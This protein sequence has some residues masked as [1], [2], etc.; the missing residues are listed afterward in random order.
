MVEK[1]Y[2]FH[3]PV[4]LQKSIA[5]LNIQAGGIYVDLTFGGGGH[6]REILKVLKEGQLWA[7]DQDPA[8]VARAAALQDERLYFV[9]GNFRFFTAFL[10]AH[11][12]NQVTGILADLGLSSHQLDTRARGFAAR[13]DPAPLDMR[14]AQTGALTA[15]KIVNTYRLPALVDIFSRYGNVP[16]ARKLAQ[17]LVTAREKKPFAT[18]GDFKAIIAP[19]VPKRRAYQ[20]YAKVFQALRI[21]VNDECNALHDMLAQVPYILAPGGRLV[22]ISYHSGE[23][24]PVKNFI[25]TGNVA[26]TVVQDAYGGLLRPLQPLHKKIIVPTAAEIAHN[27]RARSARMRVAEKPIH[28]NA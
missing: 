25:K 8:S 5:A 9:Q 11:G 18:V 21:A 6:S 7:F 27:N 3:R 4:L 14:M 16:N 1:M 24:R 12:I 23:D 10:H 26:G 28:T 17:Y 19:L 2:D 13:L 15:A 22:V 20:Y